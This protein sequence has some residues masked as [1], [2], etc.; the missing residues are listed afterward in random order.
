MSIKE[1]GRRTLSYYSD[2]LLWYK[3]CVLWKNLLYIKLSVGHHWPKTCRFSFKHSHSGRGQFAGITHNN[4]LFDIPGSQKFTLI[5]SALAIYSFLQY[6]DET[7]FLVDFS[8]LKV[9]YTDINNLQV[10]VNKHLGIL[11]FILVQLFFFLKRGFSKTISTL[12]ILQVREPQW[13]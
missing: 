4:L 5:I 13:I 9:K 11:S 1:T 2:S 3:E 10:R 7:L 12:F 6:K 8:L